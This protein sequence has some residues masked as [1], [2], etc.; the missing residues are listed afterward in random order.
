MTD[1]LPDPPAAQV[2]D[3]RVRAKE[4][5]VSE[6][7]GAFNRAQEFATT[8]SAPE[9]RDL[10]TF[11]AGGILLSAGFGGLHRWEPHTGKHEALHRAPCLRVSAGPQ[12]ALSPDGE[13]VATVSAEGIV[14]VGEVNG[15]APHLLIG[16]G[17]R[18]RAVAFSPDGRWVASTTGNEVLL[19]PMQALSGAPI[20]TLRLGELLAELDVMTN[21]R[22]I[23]DPSS[24]TGYKLDVGP[25]P[26]WKNVPSW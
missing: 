13:T 18:G 21:L 15:G 14:R 9:R 12:V 5:A 25:F 16:P 7:T 24:A 19:W 23:E 20:H 11:A 22:V 10:V 4:M 17:G 3:A 26:G 8:C 6:P 1:G 2:R